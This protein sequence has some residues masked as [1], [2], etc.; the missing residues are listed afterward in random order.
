MAKDCPACNTVNAD[1][2]TFCRSCGKPIASAPAQEAAAAGISCPSCGQSNRA[3]VK[4]CAKC[5]ASLAQASSAAV[6]AA[7]AGPETRAEP[8]LT[9]SDSASHALEPRAARPASSVPYNVQPAPANRAV[10]WAVLGAFVVVAAAAAGGVLWWAN[11]DKAP[12]TADAP[13][14]GSK[15]PLADAPPAEPPPLP[16]QEPPQAQTPP[17]A[18]EAAPPPAFDPTR[19]A[20]VAPPPSGSPSE[21][22]VTTLPSAPG[23]PAVP[24]PGDL[25]RPPSMDAEHDARMRAEERRRREQAARREAE[26]QRRVAPY[27]PPP[28][29]SYRDEPQPR[30]QPARRLVEDICA[31]RFADDPARR[32]KCEWRQCRLPE[33]EHEALCRRLYGSR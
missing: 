11:R 1:T 6:A 29:P 24:A 31:R 23:T 12:P 19:P 26:A 9:P 17:L 16:P 27:T 28:T 10:T 20:E 2:A 5:G 18:P 22:P 25:A 14:P 7:T 13:A 15:P 8:S 4:F 21:P 32:E 3:G 33:H 30:V